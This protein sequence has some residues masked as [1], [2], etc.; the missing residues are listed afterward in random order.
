MQA[1]YTTLEAHLISN[2]IALGDNLH[3]APTRTA[4]PQNLNARLA[5]HL[6][7]ARHIST[8][9]LTRERVRHA[10]DGFKVVLRKLDD[11]ESRRL[12][13]TLQSD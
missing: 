6:R 12:V 1:Y 4:F 2:Q 7:D 5:Q 10:T 8:F 11:P 13:D 3:Y 9:W